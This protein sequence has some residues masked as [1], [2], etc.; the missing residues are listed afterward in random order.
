MA[1]FDHDRPLWEFTVVSG[2]DGGRGA[3]VMKVHHALTDGIGGIQLAAL[4]V[5]L[6]R[7]PADLALPALPRA[8]RRGPF[9]QVTRAASYQARRFTSLGSAAVRTVPGALIGAVAH[10]VTSTRL[11][12][13]TAQSIARFVAPV[14]ATL[15]PVMVERRL[16]WHYATLDTSVAELKAAARHIEGGTL[17]DGFMAA[18]AGGLRRYHERHGA[19]V[20]QLRLTMPISVRTERD[21]EG[22]NKITLVR[23]EVPVGIADPVARMGAIAGICHEIRKE[24][25]IE[26]TNAIAGVFNLLPVA[27]TGGMLKHVDF[28]ASNVPGFNA[29]VYVGG[30]RLEAFYP[31][32]R[33]WARRPTSPSCPTTG[34]AIS[35]SPP[36]PGPCPIPSC[37]SAHWPRGWP[38]CS[39]SPERALPP[40]MDA[41]Q[42]IDVLAL[43]P[44]PEGGWFRRTWVAPSHEGVRPAGSAIYY[45]LEEGR[46]AALHRVDATELWHHYAGA[47]LALH[48]RPVGQP[49]TRQVLGDD[50]ARGERPQLIVPAHVPQWAETLGAFT[51]VG[52]TVT[53]AFSFEGWELLD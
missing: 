19:A 11:T 51:L 36:I 26:F 15:S 38:R 34:P 28:L 17:N 18:L 20:D 23:F 9:S 44:H 32:A 31:S 1:A 10:P 27:L 46:P 25:A 53:P 5:D 33:P 7:E 43:E 29:C 40:P 41:R 30:A 48:L 22:G 50:L 21:E 12:V 42:I 45:L 49:A 13:A 39:P 37:S 52:A 24:R 3:L 6:Q 2:L 35:A 47:P 8:P 14:T 4:V 16:Q